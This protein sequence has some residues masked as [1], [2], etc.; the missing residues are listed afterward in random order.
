MYSVFEEI[1]KLRGGHSFR[2]NDIFT[3]R[4]TV[5]CQ[6]SGGIKTAY[7]FSVPIRN[8]KTNNVVDLRFHHNNH[9]SSFI[10]SEAKVSVSDR[11]KIF[12]KHGECDIL[13]EGALSRKTEKAIFFTSAMRNIEIRPTLNGIMLLFDSDMAGG[14]AKIKLHFNRLF[15]SVR[16]NGKCFS[17]MRENLIPFM[18][19]SC[20]GAM[21]LNGK[22]SAPCQINYYKINDF[23]YVLA[24]TSSKK[25]QNRIAVEINLQETKL[26]QDTTV[27]SGNPKANNAFGGVAFLGSGKMFGEQWLYS[28]LEFSNISRLKSKRI[29]KSI[30]HIPQLND[31]TSQITVNKIA[32]RFCSFGSNWENKIA[33]TDTVAASIKSNGYYH[34]DL[35]KL[36]GGF[37]NNSENFVIRG[38][39]ASKPIAISTGDSFYSPQILEVIYN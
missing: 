38:N 36:F 34:L 7:C 9:G 21:N 6:E 8:I 18:T 16:A 31:N 25:S 19:V 22:V 10:G 23:E 28:R 27:E 3:N 15:E 37:S 26:F 14:P 12:N 24:F 20:I 13:F 11:I 2:V 1:E 32:Q 39:A 33:P 4:Y 17:V 30:M 5:H 29:I 35:T